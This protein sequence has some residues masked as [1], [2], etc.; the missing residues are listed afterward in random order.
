M[1]HECKNLLIRCMDFRLRD[2]L[3]EW[4]DRSGLFEGGF[5]VISLAGASKSLADG[6]DNIKDFLLSNIS[7]S[8]VLHSADKVVILH[9]SD[10]GA[11]GSFGF[12]SKEAEKERQLEDMMKSRDIIQAK[13]P[14]TEVVL[15]WAELKDDHGHEIEF[16]IV[17]R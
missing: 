17:E 9:H 10:C 15:A 12:P 4:I 2:E 6:N 13:Y 7:V 1:A 8:T 16:E 5:D 14:Q 3:S 11:Y